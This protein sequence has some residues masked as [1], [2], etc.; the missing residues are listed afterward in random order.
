MSS[1]AP[2]DVDKFNA[3]AK[4]WGQATLAELRQSGGRIGSRG[5]GTFMRTLR[6]RYQQR[7]GEIYGIGFQF[8]RY[9]VFAEK[10]ARKGHGGAKGSRWWNDSDT[11]VLKD[12]S[13]R[14]GGWRR[15]NP[16]SFGKMNSGASRA[17]PWFNP[18]VDRRMGTLAEMMADHVADMALNTILIR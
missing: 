14:Q 9:A 18:V 13:I 3:A 7:F 11:S 5:T 6:V 10:G 8:P 15:T 17:T 16:A 1:I 4:G 12:G 2:F